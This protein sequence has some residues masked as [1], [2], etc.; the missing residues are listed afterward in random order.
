MIVTGAEHSKARLRTLRRPEHSR[1]ERE[2]EAR[3]AYLGLHELQGSLRGRLERLCRSDKLELMDLLLNAHL[4][5]IVGRNGLCSGQDDQIRTK[6]NQGMC[7]RALSA[8]IQ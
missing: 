8:R 1:A 3:L 2:V 5:Q 7:E 6:E 4:S